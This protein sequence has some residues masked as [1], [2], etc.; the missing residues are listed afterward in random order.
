M[1]ISEMRTSDKAFLTP[2]EI[3]GV[4]GSDQHTIRMT[5]RYTPSMVR[6]PFTFVGNRMKIPRA[7]F[8]RWFDG[9]ELEV[10]ES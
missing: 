10:S 1:T 7:A 5:A 9:D 4:L 6:F 2:A 8:L 3:A